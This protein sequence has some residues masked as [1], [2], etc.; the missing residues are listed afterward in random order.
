MYE[1]IALLCYF[2]LILGIGVWSS[3]KVHTASDFI[4]GS[5]SMNYWLTAMAAHA[6]DMS[7]WLFMAYPSVIFLGGFINVWVA[8]GL[9]ICMWLNWQIVAPKIRLLT[10][11]YECS[12]LSSFFTKSIGDK[13]G[14]ISL[15]SAIFCIIFYSVYV[16]AGLVGL[17]IVTENLFGID[18][19]WGITFGLIIVAAY[20]SMGGYIALAWLDLFQGIFLLF[21]ILF[22]PIYIAMELGGWDVVEQRVLAKNLSLS[23]IP[24]FDLIGISTVISMA[25]GWGLGYFGQPHIITKFMGINHTEE[26]SKS[27]YVGMSWMFLSLAGATAVGLVGIAYFQ[28]GLDHPEAVF[29]EMAK[30][31]FH[32]FLV[33]LILCAVIASTINVMSSQ[34]LVLCSTITEDIYKQFFEEGSS[35]KREL[36]VSR[37][38]ILGVAIVSYI[39]AMAKV[40]SIFNLVLYAWSGLGASF[41]PLILM[42]IYYKNVNVYGAATGIIL[43]G[44][45]AALWPFFDNVFIVKVDA[46][47]PGFFLGLLSIYVVSKM[48]G[49]R[50]SEVVTS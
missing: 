16:C 18:Y 49:G 44:L 37:L 32:P 45:I 5:R 6:S 36:L 43:G 34:M 46:M 39:I 11:E 15:L 25:F 47:F 7:S 17:G 20:V 38:G 42:C 35:S 22:V 23:L 4:L 24:T 13:S 33:G 1:F 21:I 9:L 27:K 50:K 8:I 31:T 12:T 2:F 10:E 41:G 3:R 19:I 26:I 29:I 40:S 30:D 28:N 14:F 48:T